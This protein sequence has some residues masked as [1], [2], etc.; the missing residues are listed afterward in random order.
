MGIIKR[1]TSIFKKK[2]TSS[3]S[4]GSSSSSSS[5]SSSS[6]SSGS[7][8]PQS[9]IMTP[10]AGASSKGSSSGGGSSSSSDPLTSAYYSNKGSSSGG[11]SSSSNLP[12]SSL[13]TPT[14]SALDL[15]KTKTQAEI[16]QA[17]K[18]GGLTKAQKL[19]ASKDFS[20]KVDILGATGLLE[21]TKYYVG[22]SEVG[23]LKYGK[24]RVGRNTGMEYFTP[25]EYPIAET[26][27]KSK[28]TF[29]EPSKKEEIEFTKEGAVI[30]ETK[31]EK[32][33]REA[34]MDVMFLKPNEAESLGINIIN[35]PTGEGGTI[36]LSKD[37]LY[38]VPTGN[39][40]EIVNGEGITYVKRGEQDIEK[41]KKKFN[42]K[43]VGKLTLLTNPLVLAG[44]SDID[45]IK[46]I[47]EEG[48]YQ[49]VKKTITEPIILSEIPVIKKLPEI[50][51]GIGE[52]TVK[53]TIKGGAYLGDLGFE[54]ITGKEGKGGLPKFFEYNKDSPFYADPDV[55][56]AMITGA[57]IGLAGAGKVGTEILKWG[58]R[59]FAGYSGIEAIK[60]PT[61]ENLAYA[62][63]FT[64]PELYANRGLV[65]QEISKRKPTKFTP[66]GNEISAVSR[67]SRQRATLMLKDE[68]NNYLVSEKGIS[69]GGN[70]EK[71]ESPRN[72][73][74]RELKEELGLNKNDLEG[75]NFKEKIVTPEETFY[76]YE[77]KVKDISKIKPASDMADG[78]KWITPKEYGGITG[79]TYRNPIEKSIYEYKD[80]MGRKVLLPKGKVRMYELGIMNRLSGNKRP[81]T[82]LGYETKFGKI[83]LGT[84]SRYDVT[85]NIAKE[86]A[87]LDKEMLIHGTPKVPFNIEFGKGIKI[88]KQKNVRGGEGLYFQPPISTSEIP[89]E[90]LKLEG[91]TGKGRRLDL[92]EVKKLPIKVKGESPAGY[93]GL[94]YLDF[95]TPTGYDLTL[96][97]FSNLKRRGL[98]VLEE[99]VGKNVK[100]TKKALA[101]KESEQI[102]RF[103]TELKPTGKG[104]YIWIGG[105]KVRVREMILKEKNLNENIRDTEIRKEEKRIKKPVKEKGYENI[106]Y[107]TPYK[108]AR[109]KKG[110]SNYETEKDEF[111][112][113][114]YTGKEIKREIKRI[115][116]EGTLGE[117][118]NSEKELST[119]IG[120]GE[121]YTYTSETE[122][123]KYNYT[124]EPYQEKPTYPPPKI[125][126]EIVTYKGKGIKK[127][128]SKETGYN[129]F[130]KAPKTKK[131]IKITKK[132]VKLNEAEDTRNYFIDESVSRQ[133]FVRK[134]KQ[135]ASPLM[136]DI[137]RGYSKNTK[138]KFRRFKV[139]K[140]TK[141]PLEQRR[142]IEKS[143][144]IQDT[145]GEKKELS[146]FKLMAQ[147]EKK[148][149]NKPVW[150]GVA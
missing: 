85:G 139:K 77:A 67:T 90:V 60:N 88:S 35:E 54:K 116:K 50:V 13:L 48:I 115:P 46:T 53:G 137:P 10:T 147:K 39:I 99:K 92:K 4:S 17:V 80:I 32:V 117:T 124:T 64:A 63:L 143:K 113:K 65:L 110:I 51:Y 74:I 94:S 103:G 119:E 82:W 34:G 18:S 55:Q 42:L 2:D 16:T 56:T 128:Q 71:G 101:G 118:Y 87:M 81:V 15:T 141:I 112:L 52:G 136:Y 98:Y 58:G 145:G 127:K 102:V 27:N 23:S 45:T 93:V 106:E 107:T 149:L 44:I 73:V 79:Q 5:G 125:P 22:G 30:S 1:I 9:T 122:P 138:N 140:G 130:V 31:K 91:Y 20:G 121:V 78:I 68:K 83:Y 33:K 123:Y 114:K 49:G 26:K 100:I 142:V 70:I 75:F 61:E 126:E 134:T 66:T 69:A 133:G 150:E 29:E 7:S 104:E 95:G 129:V 131:Y 14:P 132:P 146:I 36:D 21:Q 41:E 3:S 86:Y 25:Y 19:E 120:K 40:S 89:R 97:P 111:D 6:G 24:T 144:Y 108:Y 59:T 57:T 72:A 84:Q 11:G 135:K 76:V 96:N 62:L 148:K 8:L 38:G 47:K 28:L 37:L 109:Y 43:N 105:K 12:T